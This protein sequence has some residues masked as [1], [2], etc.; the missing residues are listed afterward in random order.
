MVPPS[1]SPYRCT[2]DLSDGNISSE[3]VKREPDENLS[4][5]TPVAPPATF[6][7]SEGSTRAA[8]IIDR[9]G[10][11]Y[12]R[13]QYGGKP[14]F[15]CLIRTI[16]SQH[17]SDKASQPAF[18]HLMERFDGDEDLVHTLAHAHR[19]DI[20]EAITSAGLYNQKSRVLQRAAERVLEEWGDTDTFDKF[21]REVEPSEAREVLLSFD[22]VGPK[23]AD[24]VLLFA[25]GNEGVFPVDTHVYRIARR[26]GIAPA[27]ADHETVR[28]HLE[29][30][31]PPEACGFGHTSMIQ[32]GREYCTSNAPVCLD[33]LD[34]CPLADLCDRVGVD[35]DIGTVTDPGD[36]VTE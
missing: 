23:T 9:L 11:L 2:L 4:G 7:A 27:G 21:V 16:L 20:V 14:A 6:D 19:E 13:K 33:G 28:Q 30:T 15:E 17:T 8:K 1:S 35:P 34:D 31:I 18:E 5:D 36:T 24:C 32:F 12:W 22:G 10:D 3:M 29:R 26:L 25:G